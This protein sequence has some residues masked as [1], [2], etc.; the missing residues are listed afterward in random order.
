[1][2][3]G[4]V[5]PVGRERLAD[6]PPGRAFGALLEAVDPQLRPVCEALRETISELHAGFVEVVWLGRHT[7]SYGIGPKKLSEHYAAIAPQGSQVRLGFYR[8]AFLNDPGHL[9][10]GK[11]PRSRHVPIAD[12][13]SARSIALKH[14]IRQAISE[15]LAARA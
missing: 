6:E 7:A 4:A 14:L 15:R 11:G 2:A 13:E 1:M 9:L 8:G 3:E 10:A 5:G 12:L